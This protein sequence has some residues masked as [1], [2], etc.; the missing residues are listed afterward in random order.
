MVLYD[1]SMF[2]ARN[3]IKD[4]KLNNT[5]FCFCVGDYHRSG[6]NRLGMAIG[7]YRAMCGEVGGVRTDKFK[8]KKHPSSR[9]SLH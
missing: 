4:P 5:R 2:D 6:N 7:G 1:E 3:S 9:C 8:A